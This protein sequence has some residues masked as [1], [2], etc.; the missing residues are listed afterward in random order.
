MTFI[1]ATA[2]CGGASF[3]SADAAQVR[4]KIDSVKADRSFEYSVARAARNI[5]RKMVK[6]GGLKH[7]SNAVTSAFASIKRREI[8][9]NLSI[10]SAAG[11][12]GAAYIEHCS[13][14]N[15]LQKSIRMNWRKKSWAAQKS[16]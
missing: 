14:D 2:A 4:N 6:K 1:E 7:L 15:R 11:R 10:E 9:R 8:P 12:G 3:W 16:Q 13:G 5:E